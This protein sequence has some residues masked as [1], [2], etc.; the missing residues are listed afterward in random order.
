MH[1]DPDDS[2]RLD[3]RRSDFIEIVMII[4]QL[5]DRCPI[6]RQHRIKLGKHKPLKYRE[7]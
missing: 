1:S 2:V 6:I 5:Q 3:P 4:F 7:L